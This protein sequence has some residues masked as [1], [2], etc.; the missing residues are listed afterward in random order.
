VKKQVSRGEKW[1]GRLDLYQEATG[2]SGVSEHRVESRTP[3]EKTEVPKV[4]KAA[5]KKIDIKTWLLPSR[6]QN[7]GA[8]QTMGT[9][10]LEIILTGLRY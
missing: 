7:N 4:L 6:V 3:G 5:A 8:Q 9:M 10:L 2:W 1:I